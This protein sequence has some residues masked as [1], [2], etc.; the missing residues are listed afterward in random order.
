[1]P[2]RQLYQNRPK[3]SIR[4]YLKIS[5]FSANLGK[6]GRRVAL[7]R[8]S[9]RQTVHAAKAPTWTELSHLS[10]FS[11][12][13]HHTSKVFTLSLQRFVHIPSP[14]MPKSPHA[15][16]RESQ[17][18]APP[19]KRRGQRQSVRRKLPSKHLQPFHNPRQFGAKP[20]SLNGVIVSNGIF[21]QRVQLL[22]ACAGLPSSVRSRPGQPPTIDVL[23]LTQRRRGAEYAEVFR[24]DFSR[25]ERVDRVAAL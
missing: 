13:Y 8:Q 21:K 24:L 7:P 12:I 10:V 1:M 4:T 9:N 15:L 5:H 2:E 11:S 23:V 6:E 19:Q 20:R 14:I 3:N 22:L 18:Q 17:A 16:Y 25:A